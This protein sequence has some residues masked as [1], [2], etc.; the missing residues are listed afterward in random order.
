MIMIS[1]KI[2]I[3]LTSM[4]STAQFIAMGVQELIIP[5]PT[6]HTAMAY[7]LEN[8]RKE[9]EKLSGTVIPPFDPCLI[10]FKN[11]SLESHSIMLPLSF[12]FNKA[13][14]TYDRITQGILMGKLKY[15]LVD[16]PEYRVSTVELFKK[17]FK[18]FKNNGPKKYNAE[19]YAHKIIDTRTD[20]SQSYVIHGEKSRIWEYGKAMQKAK[21]Y[22]KL[23]EEKERKQLEKLKAYAILDTASINPAFLISLEREKGIKLLDD[24][25]QKFFIDAL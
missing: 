11:D 14:F 1:I 12:I 13:P 3:F 23:K 16:N 4:F 20:G 10:C 21:E 22:K 6:T 9:L 18:Y 7:L 2:T 15:K 24:A 19:L 17:V 25:L 8:K 5:S